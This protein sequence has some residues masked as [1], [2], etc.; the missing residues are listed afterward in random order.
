MTTPTTQQRRELMVAAAATLLIAEGPRAITHRRVA[1]AA[2]IPAGSANYLFAT[3]R[4]LYAAAVTSA[5]NVRVTAATRV[6]EALPRS[7]RDAVATAS[8]LL[9]TWYAPQTDP[10]LVRVRLEPMLEAGA[11]PELREIMAVS[12]PRLL[13]ALETVLDRCGFG[14]VG[15]TEMIA[16]MLDASLL[17]A[18]GAGE[19][20]PRLAAAR[21]V[22]RLLD[23]LKRVPRG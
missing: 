22:A 7:E 9:E 2:G 21:Q 10:N 13:A 12:R 5:E 18:V 1:D 20:D 19:A 6:A 16:Q 8:L 23:L 15:E 11:D 3:R 17:Y 14:G 4:E